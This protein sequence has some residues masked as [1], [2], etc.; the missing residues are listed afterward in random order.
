MTWAI[1][2]INTSKC[3]QMD[4]Q[5]PL[6]TSKFYS[7]C[8]R[9]DIEKSLRAGASIPP[10]AMM[11]FPPVSDFPLFS[12]I[13]LTFWKISEILP[14]SYKISHF[15]PPKFLTTFF[16]FIHH[17]FLISPFFTAFPP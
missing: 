10:E 15:H 4:P 9:I 6:K 7:R 12:R 16:L 2:T 5:Q 1:I 11:H 3:A 17:K 14:F 13:F 8:K